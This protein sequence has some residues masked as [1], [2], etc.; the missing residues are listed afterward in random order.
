LFKHTIGLANKLFNGKIIRM[1]EMYKGKILL[2]PLARIFQVIRFEKREI[3]TIYFFA[4]L[5]GLLQLSL[6]LGIQA[7]INFILA[8]A[9]S[10]SMW[11]LIF[12]VVLGVFLSGSLQVSQMRIIEKINQKLFSRYAFEFAYRIPKLDMKSVDHYYLPELINRF[13]DTISLQ[14][15]LS[16]LLL[17]IP[18]AMIQIVF[19][20]MLLS[21]YSTIFIFFGF[22][23]I[24]VLYIILYNTSSRGLITS[25]R[26]S[27]YKYGVAS[28]LEEMARVIRSF[29][30]GKSTALHIK[31]TDELVEG[32]LDA[33]TSHFK[34]L[35]WQYWSLIVFKVLITAAMLIVGSV[36]LV[37]NELNVGQ[38]VAAEI[39]ILVVLNS[40][41][42]FIVSLDKVYDV[43][44]SVE[45]LGKILDQPIEKNGTLVLSE[46][47]PGIS[48]QVNKLQ[49]AFDVDERAVINDIS[50]EV[51]AGKKIAIMGTEG[52][53]K[54][55][56]LRLLTGSY[57]D[58]KGSILLNNIPIGNYELDSLRHKT[59]IFFNQQ[60]IFHGTLL[61]NITLG[62]T[63]IPMEQVIKMSTV[64][65]LRSFLNQLP[66][67]FDTRLDPTGH[68][69]SRS[70]VHKILLMRAFA[71]NPALLLLEEPWANVDVVCREQLQQFLLN[72]IKEATVF[73]S[74]NDRAFAAKCDYILY[75]DKGSNTAFGNAAEVLKVI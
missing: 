56:L 69:L 14:K 25:L 34:V 58:F 47:T 18:T 48:V 51:L 29:K 49:F 53:G 21:F 3:S 46:T 33:R 60:D 44:T 39:V 38:F 24:V 22:F 36:L 65:N 43:L 4:I 28:W 27:D 67:G 26:E 1:A 42:K 8:G 6:P 61:E 68:R 20:L 19:G 30:F 35:Q 45:K 40:V 37:K 2:N 50:F 41:E 15:G 62:N 66:Q 71:N 32:Y 10:T 31:K 59:G 17:D 74:T 64:L 13:F 23:L 57:T 52:S 75:L 12:L 70:V 16:K 72:D 11:L 55:T 54:S 73:I 9:M 63:A 7:I 5:Y